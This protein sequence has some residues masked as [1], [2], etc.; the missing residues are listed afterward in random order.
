MSIEIHG[1]YSCAVGCEDDM[2]VIYCAC[3]RSVE[4]IAEDMAEGRRH[5]MTS[6][7]TIP[8][9][10]AVLLESKGL[11]V[12]SS[13]YEHDNCICNSPHHLY[14]IDQNLIVHYMKY[15]RPDLIVIDDSAMEWKQIDDVVDMINAAMRQ[16]R[17]RR[18]NGDPR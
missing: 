2:V 4:D 8:E 16:A 5:V 15:E 18:S 3:L 11:D 13:I 12:S 9:H 14:R 7:C 17:K 1:S 6:Y 10:V